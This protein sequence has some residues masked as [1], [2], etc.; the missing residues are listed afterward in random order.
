LTRGASARVGARERDQQRREV[1]DVGYLVLVE[2]AAERRRG[3]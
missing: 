1:D 3:W 2:R